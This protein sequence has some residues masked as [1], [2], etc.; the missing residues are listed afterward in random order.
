MTTNF[1]TEPQS[2]T[3]TYEASS[4]D[5]D[6]GA[7]AAVARVADEAPA[8]AARV[9]GDAKSQLS[10]A[11]RRVMDDL[12]TQADDRAVRAAQGLRDLS[13]RA[14]ALASGRP[15]EAGNLADL[16]QS[17]GRHA[18]DFANRLDER[19]IRGVTDDV[20]RFGRQHPLTFLGLSLGA[21]FLVGR[22][23]RTGAAVVSDDGPDS[24]PKSIAPTRP[25][26]EQF[27]AADV[28]EVR[29]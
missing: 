2:P 13:I 6:S 27:A 18:Q 25:P 3:R 20:A 19:G 9:V 4:P 7:K 26:M 28:A 1:S 11:A 17:A 14:D 15:D 16:A 22:L 24:Q 21:G 23:V 8:Q 29:V 12:R 5:G 10:D